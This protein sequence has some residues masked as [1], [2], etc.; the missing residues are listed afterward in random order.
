[1]GSWGGRT[2]LLTLIAVVALMGRKFAL[3]SAAA[4]WVINVALLA[5][6]VGHHYYRFPW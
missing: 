6:F 4:C 3:A 5:F 1:M 2:T